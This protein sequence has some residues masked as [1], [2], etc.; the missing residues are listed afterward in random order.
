MSE[1]KIRSV[2]KM[3]VHLKALCNSIQQL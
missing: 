2:E 1:L 3:P